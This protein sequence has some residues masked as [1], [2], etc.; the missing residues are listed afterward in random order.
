MV[1]WEYNKDLIAKFLM[2]PKV[3]ELF[4]SANIQQSYE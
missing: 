1:W 4:K 3:K 2:N